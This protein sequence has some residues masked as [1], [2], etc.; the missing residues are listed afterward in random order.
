MRL[1][2]QPMNDLSENQ[3]NHD[4]E[5]KA[6]NEVLKVKLEL[7]HGMQQSDSSTLSP[8]AE[9]QWLNYIYNFEKQHKEAKQV[10]VYDFISRPGFIRVEDLQPEEVPGALK[11]LL[12][13]MEEKGIGLNCICEYEDSVIYRFITEEL[14]EHEIDD[15]SMEGMMH[16]FIY[17]EFHPNHSYDL[18]Q[19]TEEF[20]ENVFQQKW[21]PQFHTTALA[22][23]VSFKGNAYDNDGISAII[24]LFQEA[25]SR[26]QTEK[27]DIEKVNFDIEKGEAT[28]LVSLEY[29]GGNEL[30][31]GSGIITFT[32]QWGYWHISSFQ[33]PGLG[34]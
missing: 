29:I 26:L 15:I 27:F 11:H 33:L 28:V 32:Y 20:I 1:I 13:V 4:D 6:E 23:A 3:L 16:N 19:Y 9:N 18:R 12:S 34:D 31:K 17:E 25:N 7:E 2:F 14:F 5:I 8:E 30:H 10:K 24:L 22:D 21:N